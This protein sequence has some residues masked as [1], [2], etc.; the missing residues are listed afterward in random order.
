MGDNDHGHPLI[1]QLAH[2]FQYLAHHFRTKGR[3]RLIKKDQLRISGYSPCDTYALLP[4]A[5]KSIGIKIDSISHS[6]L[7]QCLHGSLLRFILRYAFT[8]RQPQC[9]IFKYCFI[10]KKIVIL[11]NKS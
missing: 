10:R 5:R 3:C 11:E 1:C 4:T 8:N 7:F 2:N 6:D 9:Y